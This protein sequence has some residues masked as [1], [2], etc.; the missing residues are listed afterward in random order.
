VLYYFKSNKSF[1]L[2]KLTIR[3]IYRNKSLTEYGLKNKVFVSIGLSKRKS[4]F[5]IS[6][7]M[8]NGY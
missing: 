4:N 1:Q 2:L 8:A 7:R 5:I 6:R 3:T